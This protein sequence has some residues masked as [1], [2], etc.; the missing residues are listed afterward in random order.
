[1]RIFYVD[2]D[3]NL[4]YKVDPIN[5]HADNGGGIYNDYG[6]LTIN[7]SSL[8]ATTHIAAAVSTTIMASHHQRRQSVWQQ[9]RH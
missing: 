8:L 1:V 3:A 6:T 9:R 2:V 4:R 7:G 5:G